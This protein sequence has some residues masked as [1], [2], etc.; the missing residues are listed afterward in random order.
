MKQRL[1]DAN[2]LY[3]DYIVTS[4]T[5]NTLCYRYIS[6][7]QVENAPTIDAIPVEWIKNYMKNEALSKGQSIKYDITA[8]EILAEW[9]GLNDYEELEK[10]WEKENE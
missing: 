2:N 4:T 6:K 10:W 5:T 3:F 8:W 7:E 9:F 1:I